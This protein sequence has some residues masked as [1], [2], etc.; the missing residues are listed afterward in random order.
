MD[1]KNVR[2]KK[3]PCK[4]EEMTKEQIRE[5]IVKKRVCN[6]KAQTIVESLLE[7]VVSES[8]FLQCLPDINQSH[9]EDVIEERA[10]IH[11]CGYPLCQTALSEKDIPKQKYRISMKTNKVYDITARKSFCSNSCYRAATFVKKQMLTSPLWF[12]EYEEIPA[13][14]LLPSDTVGSLGLEVDVS[15][16]EKIEV[17]SDKSQF[18]SI[19]DFA[20]ASLNEMTDTGNELTNIEAKEIVKN[21]NDCENNNSSS[22][23][24]KHNQSLNINSVESQQD[25]Q[26]NVS[27]QSNKEFTKRVQRKHNPLNIVGDIIEKP[28][29]KIDPILAQKPD[30]IPK[31]QSKPKNVIKKC[32]PAVTV[33]TIEVEKRLAEWFTLDTLL[34]L[35]GEEKVREM[36]ADK[37]ECIKE[38]LNNYANSI[39]YNANTYDQ[40][41]ALCRKLNM[42]E[43][44]DRQFDAQTLQR[45]LKPLPDYSMLQEESKKMQLKVRAYFAG[46]MTI[47]DVSQEE[48]DTTPAEEESR[49]R[50]LPLVD[51]NAQNALRRRIVCEHLLFFALSY[52]E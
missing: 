8:Y 36:V 21:V 27:N 35:F 48:Q 17:K 38:Y 30:N 28:E 6:A 19:N 23:S 44:E 52:F 40:Y 41:Q 4:I 18:S 51:K 25:T 3:K 49:P 29:K 5:A 26:S 32:Q 37:G 13:F 9:F 15:I 24:V 22:S 45:E 43:L 39:A 1:T 34:L 12:R 16:I 7:K 31:A 42:L 50:H 14:H 10:I 46:E 20:T 11:L 2:M 47:P 33:L